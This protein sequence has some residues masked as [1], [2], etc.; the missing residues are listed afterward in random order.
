MLSDSSVMIVSR[1]LGRE[2]GRYEAYTLDFSLFM[3][4][5][6]RG[7]EIVEFWKIDEN[8][9]RTGIREAP[10]YSLERAGRV[11]EE[12]GGLVSPEEILEGEAVRDSGD[13]DP[14]PPPVQ[15]S[16]FS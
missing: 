3:E 2:G 5:R 1:H 10:T 9:R 11:L 4:P 13:V 16:L 15:P 6:R 14:S 7:I 12:N 8:R